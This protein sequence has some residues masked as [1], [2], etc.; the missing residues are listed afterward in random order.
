M[1]RL[2]NIGIL[3]YTAHLKFIKVVGF[4]QTVHLTTIDG[5]YT[6]VWMDH[7][8]IVPKHKVLKDYYDEDSAVE[9]FERY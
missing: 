9:A 2:N 4:G 3:S 6:L 7:N 5:V 8:V 1:T